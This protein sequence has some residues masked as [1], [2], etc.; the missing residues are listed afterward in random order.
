MRHV[1]QQRIALRGLRLSRRNE[2]RFTR[3]DKIRVIGHGAWR[4]TA[5]SRQGA[6]G[7]KN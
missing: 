1:F 7:R 6:A 2:S 3:D 5:G 4:K